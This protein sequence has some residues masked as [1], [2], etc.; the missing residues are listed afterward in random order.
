LKGLAAL[1][2]VV[3]VTI[4]GERLMTCYVITQHNSIRTKRPCLTPAGLQISRELMSSLLGM[5]GVI[6]AAPVISVVVEILCKPCSVSQ[7]AWQ[8]L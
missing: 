6:P 7:T 1:G 2:Q 5:P 8:G 4:R 3:S